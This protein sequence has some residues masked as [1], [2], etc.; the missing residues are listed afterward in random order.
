M[1]ASTLVWASS[2]KTHPQA[3]VP[4][5]AGT[6][7]LSKAWPQIGLTSLPPMRGTSLEMVSTSPSPCRHLL[8]MLSATIQI[9]LL[10][11]Q[12]CLYRE[13]PQQVGAPAGPPHSTSVTQLNPAPLLGGLDPYHPP[14][15]PPHLLH[16]LGTPGCTLLHSW[17]L[18]SRPCCRRNP[19]TLWA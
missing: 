7:H 10:R 13:P 3:L 11:L 14:L 1:A 18:F 5:A 19:K 4:T 12:A 17:T 6:C 2:T 15:P 8:T 16:H 9:I